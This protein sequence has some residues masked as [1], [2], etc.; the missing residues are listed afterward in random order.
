M[1]NAANDNA[2]AEKP[3]IA[4]TREQIQQ[5]T[6]N[7]VFAFLRH[8]ERAPSKEEQAL[9]VSCLTRYFLAPD[10]PSNRVQ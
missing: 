8:F 10:A 1:T 6:Q 3:T 9:L 4:F 5:I 2:P 7:A